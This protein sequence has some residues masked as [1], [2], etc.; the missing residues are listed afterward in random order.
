M[1]KKNKIRRSTKN[2]GGGRK[3]KRRITTRGTRTRTSKTH[4]RVRWFK[5]RFKGTKNERK[6]RTRRKTI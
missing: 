1:E 5:G 6:K 3:I 4:G 2:R